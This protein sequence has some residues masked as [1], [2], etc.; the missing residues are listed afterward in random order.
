MR[1]P[2]YETRYMQEHVFGKIGMIQ[3]LIRRDRSQC[4]QQSVRNCEFQALEFT[5]APSASPR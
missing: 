5:A 1:H 2:V 4:T 3:Q